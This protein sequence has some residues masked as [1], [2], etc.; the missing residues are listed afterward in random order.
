MINYLYYK[1]Y[2]ATLKSSLAEIPEFLAPIFLG[3]LICNNFIM[4]NAFMSKLDLIPFLF[5][6]K[7]QAS[8][9]S[10]ITI[11]L[12]M[13]YY[14]KERYQ[15]I[16]KKYSKES[17]KERIKGN[18]IVAVYVTISFLSIFAVAFFRAGKL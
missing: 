14:K 8:I 2:Q 16:L 18:I 9:F 12:I 4:L 15:P 11:I 1:L 6:N 10:I 3:G 5:A 13:L 17:E 7:V